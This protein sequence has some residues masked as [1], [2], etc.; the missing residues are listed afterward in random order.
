MEIWARILNLPFGWMNERRG[1]RAA[2]LIG[3]VKKLDVDADGEASGPFLRARVAIEVDKPLRRG[4][5]LQTDRKAKP[6]WFDIQ[7]EKLPFYCYSCGIMGHMGLECPK[8]PYEIKLRA[9]NEKKKK[10]QSFGQAATESFGS[11]SGGTN[12]SGARRSFDHRPSIKK[13]GTEVEDEEEVASPEKP[14]EPARQ[15]RDPNTKEKPVDQE[16]EV[17]PPGARKR[18]CKGSSSTSSGGNTPTQEAGVVPA[19]MVSDRIN[20]L[21]L[22]SGRAD[23][24]VEVPKKQKTVYVK[25]ARSAVAASCSPRR[26]Q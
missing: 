16:I 19:G 9:P 24:N 6:E 17:E 20:Q 14:K 7:F 18:K 21:G 3:P 15:R 5:M 10:P 2:G 25:K 23:D 12:R 22:A 11:S 13:D 8:L 1:S 26:A 4:V